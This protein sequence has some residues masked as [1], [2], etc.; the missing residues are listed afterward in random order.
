MHSNVEA[1]GTCS[2]ILSSGFVLF[3][4]KTFYPPSFSRN[5]V[6]V[7]RLVPLGFSFNISDKF[8]N[9]YCKSELVGIG[10]L[11]YG[12]FRLNLQNYTSHTSMH[13]HAG[14]KRCVINKNSSI[15]WHQRL[16]HISIERIKRLV[17]DEVLNTLDFIDFDTCMDC[18]KGKQT[19]K[20]NKVAQ[21]S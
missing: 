14:I 15:L 21:R 4:E 18:I 8:C 9:V 12:L 16:D 19:N 20:R 10:T 17:N 11:S 3:L 7:S 13:V 6:S 2:L 5:L 1:I